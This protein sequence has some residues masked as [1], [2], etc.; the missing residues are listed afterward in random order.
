[1]VFGCGYLVL[2]PGNAG[3]TVAAPQ[4]DMLATQWRIAYSVGYL[5][6]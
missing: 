4:Y 5:V 6:K 3:N 1:M 2:L